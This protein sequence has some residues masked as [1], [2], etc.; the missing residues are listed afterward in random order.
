MIIFPAFF[1]FVLVMS[2]VLYRQ[3]YRAADVQPIH[4][5]L[6]AVALPLVAMIVTAIVVI[7]VC[8]HLSSKRRRR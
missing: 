4:D 5:Q 3:G 8:N 2:V 6:L 1:L 7:A